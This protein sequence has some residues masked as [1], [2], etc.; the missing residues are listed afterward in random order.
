MGEFETLPVEAVED[1]QADARPPFGA[2]GLPVG[3]GGLAG[4]DQGFRFA[5]RILN[6]E[7]DAVGRNLAA[8]PAG[9][10]GLV[11]GNC[12]PRWASNAFLPSSAAVSP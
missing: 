8:V 2:G 9:L 1:F 11:E 7:I 5:H 4:G 10:A 6:L 12:R 3:H